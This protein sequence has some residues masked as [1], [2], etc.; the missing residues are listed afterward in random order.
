MPYLVQ[1]PIP[2]DRDVIPAGTI[3][4]A[5]GWRNLGSLL[6]NRYLVEVPAPVETPTADAP[7]RKA[8]AATA[9]TDE[10]ADVAQ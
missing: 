10:A 4:D 5:S 2:A 1:K 7:K 8:K 3:V 9:V 6:A